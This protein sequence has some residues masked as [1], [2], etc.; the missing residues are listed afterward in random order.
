MEQ[1][2]RLLEEIIKEAELFPFAVN[3]FAYV[4]S[5]EQKCISPEQN[6]VLGKIIANRILHYFEKISIF[7]C[8]NLR[9]LIEI[10]IEFGG[11]EENHKLFKREIKINAGNA[12]ILLSCFYSM[13]NLGYN[14]SQLTQIVDIEVVYNAIPEN[15]KEP[16]SSQKILEGK[17]HYNY[18][19]EWYRQKNP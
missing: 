8:D 17:K 12:L 3:F 1:R 14:F 18:F 9:P 5:D 4:M 2:F 13:R 19:L 7:Q 16:L 15:L 10:L 11:K 6:T